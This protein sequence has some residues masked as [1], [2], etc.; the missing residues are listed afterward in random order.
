MYPGACAQYDAWGNV[1]G[2]HFETA[3]G[4]RD[5]GTIVMPVEGQGG[6]FRLG[7]DILSSSPVGTDQVL[8]EAFQIELGMQQNGVVAYGAFGTAY[9]KGAKW[10]GGV[11]WAGRYMMFVTDKASGNK[12]SAIVD[13]PAGAQPAIDL[14]AIC[15]GFDTC[16]Y[17]SGGPAHDG[18]TFH[19]MAPTRILDT[20]N[21]TGIYGP[22]RTG[23]GRHPSPDPITRRE[24]TANHDLQV[25]G[26]NGIPAER[27]VGGAPQRHRRERRNAGTGLDVDHSETC[28]RRGCVQ[29]PRFVRGVSRARR[30]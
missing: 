23:D 29:R 26:L 16:N 25:T 24:E 28:P 2:V 5:L 10:T 11:G 3:P 20:R 4:G 30:T 17:L 13:I 9:N 15:F 19:A 22:V 1:G 21:L 18:G 12:I 6:A 7:G 8:V 14:D 27:R